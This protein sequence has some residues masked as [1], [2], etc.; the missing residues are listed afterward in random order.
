MRETSSRLSLAAALLFGALVAGTCSAWATMALQREPGTL[1]L[2][3]RVRVD[4]GSCPAGQIKE[5]IAGK[6]TPKGV[7]RTHTCVKK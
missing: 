5:V 7:V 4:D 1:L 2:G 6:L 3:Q